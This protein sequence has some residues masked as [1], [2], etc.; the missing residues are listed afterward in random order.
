MS[1]TRSSPRP[2]RPEPQGSQPMVAVP[3]YVPVDFSSAPPGHRYL[4]YL[5]FWKQDWSA[6]KEG[7]QKALEDLT[8][9]P[10]DSKKLMQA[11]AERQLKTGKAL[12]AKIVS[13]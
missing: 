10:A 1:S 4:L 7:K 13:A 12:G 2:S 6:I 9:L 8:S 3:R 11:L 5:P